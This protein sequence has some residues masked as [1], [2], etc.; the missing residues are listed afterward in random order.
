[1][2]IE[3]KRAANSRHL[4]GA[5]IAVVAFEFLLIAGA[6][7]GSAYAVHAGIDIPIELFYIAVV[8]LGGIG[9]VPIVLLI[10]QAKKLETAFW[11]EIAEQYGYTY[12]HK[13]YFQES[14]LTFQEGRGRATGHG[15]MGTV[16]DRP[17]RFFQNRY[18]VREGK[19][20]RTH[21]YCVSEIVFAGSFP[22]IYLNNTHNRNLSNLKTFFLPRIPLPAA[23]E[24]KFN[25]HGPKGY[26]IEVLEIFT[27]DLLLHVLDVDWEHDLELVE[28]KLYIFREKALRTKQ[29]LDDEMARLRKLLDILAPK[30]NRA[31][32]TPIGDLKSTL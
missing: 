3:E 31:K 22:H 29:E 30:L 12:V 11:K 5:I 28:Q 24:D 6:T 10:L 13:P 8:T 2:S 25:L 23:L 4:I 19:H 27:P 17:F 26:E 1:M 20:A 14:A 15:L 7:A 18:T 9:M 32:L 16:L 21:T